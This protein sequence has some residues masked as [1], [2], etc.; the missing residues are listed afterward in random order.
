MLRY[1]LITGPILIIALLGVVWFD[2]AIAVP[3]RT[4]R[5]CAVSACGARDTSCSP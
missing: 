5:A 4:S 2:W 3:K 1:R